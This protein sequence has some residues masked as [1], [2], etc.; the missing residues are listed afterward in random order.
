MTESDEILAVPLWINGHAYL[1][2]APAF[3]DVRD[4]HTGQIR[5]RTPLCGAPAARA[6]VESARHALPVWAAL[7]S[8][9]RAARLVGLGAA[10]AEYAE[11]FAGLIAE[12]TG[13]DPAAAAAEVAAGLKI[14]AAAAAGAAATGGGGVVAVV[15]DHTAPLLGPLKH[16]VPALLAGA[17]VILKPSPKT[18]AAAFALAE[19]SAR[20][21]FPGGV[22]N[23]LH[24]DL[25]AVEG[26]CADADVSL[27][28]FA[29][30]PA[31]GSKVAT[32]ATRHGK[33]FID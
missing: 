26:L 12:E 33:P 14:L 25:A 6:A 2:M 29:G 1:T 20:S 19:L 17:T 8:E 24:G 27:L 22:F 3:F 11:H 10:L 21:G 13:C 31:L 4:P 28:L 5:R 30:E 9:A 18:P 15:S 23:L 16:A 32:I 7:T